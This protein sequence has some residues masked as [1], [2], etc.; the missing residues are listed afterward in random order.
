MDTDVSGAGYR[1]RHD[2]GIWEPTHKRTGEV[3]MTWVIVTLLV[4]AVLAVAAVLIEQRRGSSLRNHFG[5][6]YDRIVERTGD[7]REARAELRERIKRRKS[8]EIRE[9]SPTEQEAYV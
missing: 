6:E 3:L 5:S 8:L 4:V 7:R 1:D 9:L 2:L